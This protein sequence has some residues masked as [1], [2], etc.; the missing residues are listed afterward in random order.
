MNNEMCLGE[1][2][3]E[4]GDTIYFKRPEDVRALRGEIIGHV[5]G[6]YQ[7]K[8]MRSATQ[9]TRPVYLIPADSVFP[10]E[11]IGRNKPKKYK[12]E[13]NGA[14]LSVAVSVSLQRKVTLQERLG[15]DERGGT[16]F[17]SYANTMQADCQKVGI[18]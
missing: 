6:M 14:G 16:V 18:V 8:G 10:V 15:M 1:I 12:R 3:F 7:V 17:R 9:H 11:Q 4:S 5:D 13:F 2:M